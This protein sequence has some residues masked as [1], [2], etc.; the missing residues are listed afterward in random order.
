[1]HQ[2]FKPEFLNRIDAIVY[3]HRL[4]EKIIENIAKIQIDQL[5]DRLH[6]RHIKLTVSQEAIKELAQ[7]GYSEEFGARPLKRTIQQYLMIPISQTLLKN[8]GLHEISVAI[9]DGEFM[10][11]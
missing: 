7:R 6:E 9:K 1:L 10:V 11:K 5:K 2:T 8:P 3:F 4:N